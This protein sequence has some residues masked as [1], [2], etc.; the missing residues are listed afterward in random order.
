MQPPLAT[1]A[2][3]LDAL[4]ARFLYRFRRVGASNIRKFAESCCE[5]LGVHDLPREARRY[6]PLIGIRLESAVLGA[7]V[8][9]VWLRL[10]D[11][12]VIQYSRHHAGKLGVVLWHEFFEILSSHPKFPTRL[13]SESEERLAT[14]FAVHVTMPESEVRRQAAELGHAGQN[15]SRVLA[16]RFGVSHA[17]MLLRLRE[18]GLEHPGSASRASYV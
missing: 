11:A 8:R 5:F 12:Y 1:S 16:S 2:D 7:G 3:E 9:A 18:L 14:L 10:P 17:A 6:L 4:L 13:P 15:K